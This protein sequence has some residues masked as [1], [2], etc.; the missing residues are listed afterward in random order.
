MLEKYIGKKIKITTD[1]WDGE[2]TKGCEYI[3]NKNVYG[4]P[5]VVNDMGY[6][7]LDILCYTDDWEFV[8]E[9]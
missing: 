7:S 5:T 3:I 8:E 2:F 6:E 4:I 9:K 1:D